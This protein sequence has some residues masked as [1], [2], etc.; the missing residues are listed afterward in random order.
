MNKIPISGKKLCVGLKNEIQS[1][2][3]KENEPFEDFT[4][5]YH[6]TNAKIEFSLMCS[7]P[8]DDYM[9]LITELIQKLFQIFGVEQENSL[10]FHDNTDV[11]C[12]CSH[13]FYSKIRIV[14]KNF[15]GTEWNLNDQEL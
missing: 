4:L 11:F 7:F 15:R 14:R 1:M 6:I 5:V 8:I 3:E 10:H 2:L 12:N 13:P 9:S